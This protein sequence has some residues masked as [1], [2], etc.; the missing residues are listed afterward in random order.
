M[1]IIVARIIIY[2]I[3]SIITMYICAKYDDKDHD[4]TYII[5][6]LLFPITWIITVLFAIIAVAKLKRKQ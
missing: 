5:L 1:N 6:G 2:I 4:I 3:L